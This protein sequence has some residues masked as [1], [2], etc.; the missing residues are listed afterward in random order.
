MLRITTDETP[1]VLT[2]RL[3]GRLEGPWVEVLM[4]CWRDA[5]ARSESRRRCVD[6]SG[7]TF[8]DG[9]GKTRL[10]QMYA[11]HAE[12]IADDLMT[13]AIVAEI[14]GQGERDGSQT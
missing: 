3:E 1:R 13:K 8:I 5:M 10:A 4:E 2:L 11:Q 14:V 7:M 6:L 9:Q 12:F